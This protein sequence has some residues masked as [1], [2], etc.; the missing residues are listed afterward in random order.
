MQKKTLLLLIT[1][2]LLK[3]S[4]GNYLAGDTGYTLDVSRRMPSGWKAGIWF[5]NT[6]ISAETFGEGSFDK[7]FYIHI[8]FNIFSKNYVKNVQGFSLRP[9]T[10]DG[11][12][13][14]DINNR[15]IDS[16]YGSS[17]SEFN[18]NWINYLD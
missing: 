5:S 15:L 12:Q 17:L 7:G 9:M 14:L 1:N 4:Y 6:N 18:E 16:F 8:P 10:R 13:K 11:A 3:W 2:I